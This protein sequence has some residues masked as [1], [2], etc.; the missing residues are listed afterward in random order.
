MS[1]NAALEYAN[2]GKET[3]AYKV[4]QSLD[5]VPVKQ[6]RNP[7]R[8]EKLPENRI[9]NNLSTIKEK[10]NNCEV[11]AAK[12]D[13]LDDKH[14][15]KLE[16][17]S[18]KMDQKYAAS[19]NQNPVTNSQKSFV[20]PSSTTSTPHTDTLLRN[21]PSSLRMVTDDTDCSVE[22]SLSISKIVDYLG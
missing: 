13:Q 4:D 9:M 21:F 2:A 6:P 17:Q 22:N 18:Y 3:N 10:M 20:H 15:L 11:A 8:E 16:N 7:V 1:T 5:S 12:H 19:S 14:P